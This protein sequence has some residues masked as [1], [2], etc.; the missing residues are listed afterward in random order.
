MNL[1]ILHNNLVVLYN[2]NIAS[3]FKTDPIEVLISEIFSEKTPKPIVTK[4]FDQVN[5][6]IPEV[7]IAI[8]VSEKTMIITDQ[9]IGDFSKK[10][11]SK[12]MQLISEINKK[13]NKSVIAYGYNYFYE[14][15]NESFHHLKEKLEKKF[16]KKNLGNE[17]PKNSEFHYLL[18]QISFKLEDDTQVTMK[19]QS[20]IGNPQNA[21]A[22]KLRVNTNVHHNK[23]S[24]P[25][26]TE[27]N[28]D[29]IALEKYIS[30]YTQ[31]IFKDDK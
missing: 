2:E 6:F 26:L 1:N 18:P 30:D 3:S 7:Q 25:I 12:F 15:E 23:N 5:I 24:L 10:N 20:V 19:F 4:M 8:I 9:T 28:R 13:V 22:N 27:L 21:E 16:C 11:I 31:L 17:M 14:L 29:Y